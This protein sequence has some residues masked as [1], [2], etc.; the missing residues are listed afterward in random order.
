MTTSNISNLNHSE[1]AAASSSSRIAMRVSTGSI[2]VNLL[3]SLFKLIAGIIGHSGAMISD[4][5]HS[6]SDV[7][8]TIIVMIGVSI[9]NKAAD[10]N[11]PYGHERLECV[12]STTLAIVLAL[13][14]GGIGYSALRKIISGNA[15]T[16][17]IPGLLAL[18]A[19]IVSI[20]AKEAMY[21]I[22]KN[23]AKKINSDALMA[24]AWHH[25]S[26][27]LSSI[28]AFIG[29]LGAR[30]GFPILDPVAGLVI[31]LFIE[32]AAFDIYKSAFDKMVDK[33]CPQEMI[34]AIR[35][36][37]QE[38]KDILTIDDLK[39]R[40]FGA[41]IYV[42]V[43]IGVDGNK[44]LR[45]AHDIAR[46]VHLTLEREFPEIKHCMVHENPK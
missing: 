18:I 3:L 36:V 26:D 38:Q 7:F 1:K 16:L 34:D 33:A 13:T 30:L 14:G 15:A 20:I 43:S 8:S 6:A 46:I 10:Q 4:A 11:H 45:E 28:G 19:A 17:A 42:D 5:I 31:C 39:T 44:T 12:A 32:K 40:Q 24:D 37:I 2:V 41:K 27:A 22:T 29:I 25:R 23:A 21:Q 35:Q 9:A